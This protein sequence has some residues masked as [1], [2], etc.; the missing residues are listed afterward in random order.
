MSEY[1]LK[2]AALS[3][4]EKKLVEE[5]SRLLEKRK[6]EIAELAEKTGLL[7]ISNELLAGAFAEI[8]KFVTTGDNRIKQWEEHGE[9]F[10][11]SKRSA[12]PSSK[13]QKS[14]RLARQDT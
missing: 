7:L 2:L 1:A 12:T 13:T 11:N 6:N 10:L 9:K 8:A 3:E 4:K 5:K 14:E